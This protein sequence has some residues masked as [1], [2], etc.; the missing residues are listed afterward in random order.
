M[1]TWNTPELQELNLSNTE[2]GK[3]LRKHPDASIYDV[4]RDFTYYTFSGPGDN[5][6]NPSHV[7]PTNP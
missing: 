4:D 5:E 3:A 2:A 7:I 1:K 6:N